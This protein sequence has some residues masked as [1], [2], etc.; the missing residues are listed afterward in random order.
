MF[1]W[2]C[3]VYLAWLANLF[4]QIVA[5]RKNCFYANSRTSSDVVCCTDWS[6]PKTITQK[7]TV[8][9]SIY[10]EVTAWNKV[11]E[12]R[13]KTK[14]KPKS[15]HSRSRQWNKNARQ[16]KRSR[17]RLSEENFYRFSSSFHECLIDWNFCYIWLCDF[18][19]LYF[20]L[21]SETCIRMSAPI[22]GKPIW[23]NRHITM[24]QK[25]HPIKNLNCLP[26]CISMP[27]AEWEKEKK[28]ISSSKECLRQFI[29]LMHERRNE[30]ETARK[31]P[32]NRFILQQLLCA[33]LK[34][35]LNMYVLRWIAL[36]TVRQTHTR[37]EWTKKKKK[38]KPFVQLA[39]LCYFVRQLTNSF[40]FSVQLLQ[41]GYFGRLHSCSPLSLRFPRLRFNE[42][43]SKCVLIFIS[44]VSCNQD[45][46]GNHWQRFHSRITDFFSIEINSKS[47]ACDCL[48]KHYFSPSTRQIQ[49]HLES[50]WLDNLTE[51]LFVFLHIVDSQTDC[52]SYQF[53]DIIFVST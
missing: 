33:Q 37:I 20:V 11:D 30:T 25:C 6:L 41:C 18:F 10:D 52:L 28:Q 27:Q 35:E 12:A 39:K 3:F 49:R 43:V 40:A 48:L 15:Q 29:K 45:K 46:I 51:I 16:L 31:T 13:K 26:K 53:N 34:H 8:E 32:I 23:T 17:N 9:S 44:L 21:C 38:K 22:K 1:R 2:L 5:C 4:R 7:S 47:V 24:R 14:S 42:G 19:F 50:K 36:W